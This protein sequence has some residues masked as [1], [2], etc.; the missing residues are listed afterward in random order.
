MMKKILII[1]KLYLTIIIVFSLNIKADYITPTTPR[2]FV[3]E[4]TKYYTQCFH[5]SDLKEYSIALK[6]KNI[7]LYNLV[8]EK[9]GCF[10]A[11]KNRSVLKELIIDNEKICKYQVKSN[12]NKKQQESYSL[13][14]CK[15]DKE[16]KDIEKIISKKTNNLWKNI[17][18]Y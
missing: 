15:T 3:I 1:I 17:K 14:A 5:L 4:E 12:F 9:R 8:I 13:G 2:E 7:K 11:F 18:S 6:T 16:F 10:T